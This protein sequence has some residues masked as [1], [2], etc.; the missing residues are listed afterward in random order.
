MKHAFPLGIDVFL[1]CGFLALAMPTRGGTEE[2]AVPGLGAPVEILRDRW[3]VAHIYARNEHDL[4]FAQGFNVARDRLFQLEL[5]RRQ[6]TGTMAEIQGEIALRRDIGARLLRFRGDMTREVSQYHP[7]GLEIVSAFVEGINA[8]VAQAEQAPSHLPIEF[9][10]LGIK[11]GRWTPEVVV[12]RHN[13]LFR[14]LTNELRHVQFVRAMGADRASELFNLHP[15]H[16]RLDPDPGLDLAGIGPAVVEPYSSARASIHFQLA[17]V[18]PEYRGKGRLPGQEGTVPMAKPTGGDSSTEG[19]NNWVLSGERTSTRTPLLAN[20]PHRAMQLPSLRYWVHLVAP[21]WNVIG[22][23]EPA[24]PGVS[25]GHNERGAWGFTIFPV[26][27]EDLYVYETDPNDR[28]RYRYRG[29]WEAMRVERETVSV[30]GQAPVDVELKFT[31]HGPLLHEDHGR[32]RAYAVKA[33]WLE[34]GAAPYLA[35]LRIDQASN[36]T[37]FREACEHFL[38]PSENLVWADVDGHIGW[39]A[40]GL[41]PIRPNWNG[42]LPVPGDGRFEWDGYLPARELPRETDP[43]RGWIATA[44]Q[45]NLPEGY[46]FAVGFEW[47]DPFRFSRIEEVLGASRKFTLED[48]TRLQHD[49]LSLPARSLVPLLR[50]QQFPSPAAKQAAERLLAWDI[51]LDRESV[52][53]A[54]YVAWEKELRKSIWELMVPPEVRSANPATSPSTVKIIAWLTKPDG[55]FGADP[56]AGRDALVVKALDKAVAGLRQRL[57]PDMS[58]WQYGQVKFKHIQLKHPLSDIVRADLQARLDLEPL[59]RGGYAHTVNSTSDADNQATGASFRIIA[60]VGDWDRSLGTNTPGQSGDP[61]NV[62]Y[63]DLYKPWA[64]GQYFPAYFS[65]AKVESVTEAKM[66][67]VPRRDSP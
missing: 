7:R 58:R 61:D 22:A 3:G 60:D 20:D 46:P 6:S 55:R 30:K 25:V 37:E 66:V 47:T 33:A 35:T 34:E 4:F 45:D 9:K 24:L 39:Q 57:G 19:S 36:W 29:N 52:P 26:D 62:H 18:K 12:S 64:E 1:A 54:I 17:D 63:R 23:G 53:A 56:I 32:H 31:R 67:L 2:L 16:P 10:I 8:F 41:A 38:T 27:Q 44:N 65:R 48:M 42:L 50:G 59:P 13:G 11:P 28:S 14:N 51:V 15:G 49:E 43:A 5:W 40:V 21:G